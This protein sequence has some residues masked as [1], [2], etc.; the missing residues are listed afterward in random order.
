MEHSITTV[1][2]PLGEHIL[3]FDLHDSKKKNMEKWIPREKGQ[4]KIFVYMSK[5]KLRMLLLCSKIVSESATVV[6]PV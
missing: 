5:T 4:F 6:K 3:L 1:P 2:L